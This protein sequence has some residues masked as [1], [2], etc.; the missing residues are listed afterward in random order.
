MSKLVQDDGWR[1]PDELWKRMELLLPERPP[2]PLGCHNP[3]VPDRATMDA[4]FFI[5]RTGS[6][7]QALRED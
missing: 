1:L 6:Q 4:I 2:H 5:L 3:R 7:W